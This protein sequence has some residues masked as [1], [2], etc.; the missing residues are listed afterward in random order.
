MLEVRGG[1][2]NEAN[3]WRK[4]LSRQG[5]RRFGKRSAGPSGFGALGRRAGRLVALKGLEGAEEHA[6][7]RVDAAMQAGEGI[8]GVLVGVPDRGTVPWNGGVEEFGLGE[9]LV[10]AFDLVIPELGFDDAEAD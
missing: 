4:W 1:W 5:G 8:E 2:R 3:L 9:I 6:I 7:G 10:E